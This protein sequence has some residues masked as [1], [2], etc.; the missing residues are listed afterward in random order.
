[1][2]EPTE[3]IRVEIE[4]WGPDQDT[5]N[6]VRQALLEHPVL[7][8]HLQGATYRLLGLD[9]HDSEAT[10]RKTNELPTPPES[11][12]ATVWDYT[13]SRA[14]LIDGRFDNNQAAEIS[15]SAGQPLPANEE[16][17]VAVELLRG[18]R[19]IGAAL[20]SGEL[21]PYRPMPPLVEQELPD[22]RS[23]RIVTVG[24]APTGEDGRHEIVG[25]NLL[26]GALHRFEGGAPAGAL[27]PRALCGFPDANQPTTSRTAGSLRV[28]VV[29]GGTVLWT[30][31]VVR[32]AAS[33]GTRGSGVELR[34]LDYRGKRV[35]YRGHVPILNVSYDQNRCGPFR[36]WQ[37]QEG[38][39]QANLGV[40]F[41][42]GFRMSSPPAQTILDTGRDAGNFRGVAISVVGQEVVLVS[43]LEAGWYRYISEWRL[44]SDGTIRPRFGFTAVRDPCVCNRHHHH[45]Y[46]QPDFDI[47]TAGNN[48]VR[49]FN[50]PP[51]AG[52]SNWH[53]KSFETRRP[54]DPGR[55]R[56]WRVENKGTGEGYEVFP[57]PTDGTAFNSPDWPYPRGDVWLLAYNGSE[58][59]DGRNCTTGGP[60]C[61]TEADL[62]R[63][64]TGQGID[65]ADVVMWYAAHFTHEVGAHAGHIVGPTLRPVNW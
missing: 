33:S 19:E 42:P 16:F 56:R 58:L 17:E 31:V 21:Q 7:R 28:T 22:G 32:P 5:V 25:V 14:L 39:F 35:L 15:E 49:E 37:N 50:D 54:R 45:A 11:Y 20:S 1:M 34:F 53:N 4:P 46:W 48:L 13:N 57:G 65:G 2:P 9:L 60:N 36:D 40:D 59:D 27:G 61:A 63:F 29:Q 38:A 12:R 64:I 52:T 51:L 8:E 62:D 55:N 44:H 23:Q 18:D 43:E 47:Q 26:D 41:A 30:F 10:T 6:T 24:L 3:D